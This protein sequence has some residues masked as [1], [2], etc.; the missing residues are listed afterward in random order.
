MSEGSLIYRTKEITTNLNILI[1]SADFSGL[2][3]LFSLCDMLGLN[4]K[5]LEA[6]DGFRGASY[7]N[8]YPGA[9]CD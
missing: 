9:G 8:Q 1:I 5:F 6:G 3:Q 7:W 4:P 2:H